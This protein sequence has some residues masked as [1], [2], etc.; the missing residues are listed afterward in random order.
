M[1]HDDTPEG[2]AVAAR[3]TAAW[4]AYGERTQAPRKRIRI[5]WREVAAY[6]GIL[7]VWAACVAAYFF[8]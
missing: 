7:A 1:M 5:D 6:V 4:L 8:A 2:R 3:T